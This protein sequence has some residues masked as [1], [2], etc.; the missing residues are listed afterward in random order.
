MP[1][2]R[3]SNCIA[4]NAECTHHNVR[5]RSAPYNIP[6]SSRDENNAPSSSSVLQTAPTTLHPLVQPM[7]SSPA[8]LDFDTQRAFIALSQHI[9]ELEQEISNLKQASGS[10]LSSSRESPSSPTVS[11]KVEGPPVI[12]ESPSNSGDTVHLSNQ[13]KRLIISSSH[14]RH[15]GSGSTMSLLG[16]ALQ[17][18][19]EKIKVPKADDNL[20]F[21]RPQFWTIHPWEDISEEETIIYE[22]PDEELLYE[23]VGLYFEHVNSHFPLLHQPTFEKALR[24]GLHH[25]D[26]HFGSTVL[27]VCAVGSRYTNNRKVFLDGIESELT[28]G[29][30]WY[31]Q[32]RQCW[33][34]TARIPSLYSVQSTCLAILYTHGTSQPEACWVM[35]GIG[36]RFVQDV[37]AHRKRFRERQPV[38]SEL[39]KRCFWVLVCIDALVCSFL[40]RPRATVSADFDLDLPVDCDDEYWETAD[41]AQ[42]FQQPPGKPSKVSA[43]IA[44]IRLMEILEYAQRTLYAINRKRYCGPAAT[45]SNEE[46][47]SHLDSELN[48]WFGDLPEHLKWASCTPGNSFYAQ[49]ALLHACYYHVRILVHRPFIPL[50]KK[51]S[52][53]PFPSLAICTNAARS[54]VRILRTYSEHGAFLPFPQVQHAV[55]T[56]GIVLLVNYWSHLKSSSSS[57]DSNNEDLKNVQDTIAILTTLESRWTTAGRF[58]DVVRE[59]ASYTE[60]SM[61]TQPNDK[62]D[63]N[64]TRDVSV[65]ANIQLPSSQMT[66]YP[67]PA[68]DAPKTP[69][70]FPTS[71]QPLN[72]DLNNQA[73]LEREGIH[74][75][76]VDWGNSAGIQ[77]TNNL[78]FFATD[79]D[80]FGSSPLSYMSDVQGNPQWSLMTPYGDANMDVSDVAMLWLQQPQMSEWPWMDVGKV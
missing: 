74:P 11:I 63:S 71:S 78:Q 12:S 32:I 35:L 27:G 48:Q 25:V 72:L 13:L 8:S 64:E 3:C 29:W 6:S 76:A 46:I 40:G 19:K 36:I 18:G 2:N 75:S 5:R 7:L 62:N 51:P 4:F 61:S 59:I 21:R 54:C 45:Q 77:A 10:T 53:L 1:D 39:W 60:A 17:V 68:K 80:L 9:L 79:T 23:L 14:E 30:K 50:P 28:A 55:F 52:P 56:S 58:C 44:Y 34:S 24:E 65:P 26:C 42:A 16:V 70:N 47:V 73:I 66:N 31:S 33:R 22:F 43:F 67:S 69:R 20:G 49:S 41:P 37:G 38:E 57:R 15:F